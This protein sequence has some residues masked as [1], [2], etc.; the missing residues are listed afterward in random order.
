MHTSNLIRR[1]AKRIITDLSEPFYWFLTKFSNP[2]KPKRIYLVH[3]RKT[4]GT[5]LNKMFLAESECEPTEFYEELGLASQRRLARNGLVFVGWHSRLLNR[6]NYFY[7]FSHVPLHELNLRKNTF[8]ITC[9]RDPVKRV[10]SH[11]NM[12]MDY[13][14]NGI[15]NRCLQTE[16]HLVGKGFE[17]FLD[18][19]PKEKLLNQLYMFSKDYSVEE[20]VAEVEK[21]SHFFFTEA[22]SSG[23]EELNRL[24]GLDLKA[25]HTRRSG[26]SEE[27]SDDSLSRLRNLLDDEYAFL[28]RL[29]ALKA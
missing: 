1:I 12:L 16:G 22:F 6:G 19:I 28:D 18:T 11:Y 17:H 10:V 27:I 23:V 8:T 21:L 5:S 2:Q 3:I 13:T 9:F 20:A 15:E 7:G 25:I 14:V 24:T 26:Y 4:G 29:R